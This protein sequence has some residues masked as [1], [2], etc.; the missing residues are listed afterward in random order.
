MDSDIPGISFE[1]QISQAWISRA[2]DILTY[3]KITKDIRVVW[4]PDG[5]PGQC[6]RFP[7]HS[8]WRQVFDRHGHESEYD[9]ESASGGLGLRV[10]P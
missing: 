7:S 1:K 10:G 3:P 4:I 8:D 2:R 5:G 6:S 9:S